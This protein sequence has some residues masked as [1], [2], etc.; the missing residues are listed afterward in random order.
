MKT[1][2]LVGPEKFV[3]ENIEK[4]K[5]AEDEVLIKVDCCGVCYSEM[6]SWDGTFKNYPQRI[7]HEIAGIVE[8]VGSNVVDFT[9]GQ[10]VTAFIDKYGYS[11][12]VSVE[13]DCVIALGDN[14]DLE[15]AIGEPIGCVVNGARRAGIKLGDTVVLVGVGF[16]GLIML[17]VIRS[18]GA[19]RI[20]A[21]DTRKEALESA[22]QLGADYVFNPLQDNVMEEVKKLTDEKGAD[23]VIELTGNQQG[24]DLSGEL[25]KIRGRLVVFGFH[26]SE[27]KVNMFL[28]NWHGIDVVNA[29]DRD[30][31]AYV[32]GIRVGMKLLESGQLDMKPLITHSYSLDEIN[33]AFVDTHAKPK[34]FI[35]AIVKM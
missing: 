4:P 26:T 19:S 13:P 11:E 1:A 6:S 9:V 28:W 30:P 18:L 34:G 3:L 20:I 33:Q 27:R 35:K 22:K 25:V 7:G 15:Q 16:M 10:K 5:P 24:L 17:Q 23:V 32:D 21:V 12:Y 8:K 31:A 29:H 2:V 14:V